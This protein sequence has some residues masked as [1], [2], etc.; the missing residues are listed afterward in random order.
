MKHFAIAVALSLAAG[1]LASSALTAQRGPAAAQLI[2]Y[3][4][5]G[6]DNQR[7][8]WIKDEKIL[9]KDNVRTLRLQWKLQTDNNPRAM[10][11]LN[12]RQSP[13]RR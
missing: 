8:G 3:L 13:G 5:D 11:A 10:H 12:A 2:D 9:T 4:T 7:T 1:V 6:A